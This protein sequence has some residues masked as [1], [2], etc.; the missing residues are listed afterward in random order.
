[1]AAG[2]LVTT[3]FHLELRGH[4]LGPGTRYH[5]D[6]PWGGLFPA[7]KANDRA[8]TSADGG[9]A[10]VDR[11]D[12]RVLTFP[13]GFGGPGG[14]SDAMDDLRALAVAWRRSQGDEELWG[15]LPG[16]GR[17]RVWG[18]PRG[19][20]EDLTMLKAGEGRALATFAAVDD[21]RLYI[22]PPIE[23]D[24][25][26]GS[27][28]VVPNP[29][30]V[31]SPWI[32]TA[33]GAMTGPRIRNLDTDAAWRFDDLVLTAD[34]T[35]VLDLRAQSAF[36]FEDGEDPV[37]VWVDARHDGDRVAT[38]WGI[39]PGGTLIG[40]A[41]EGGATTAQLTSWEAWGA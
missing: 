5:F 27:N 10:G 37:D 39:E 30:N 36:V 26:E 25:E 6:G 41:T 8:D 34:Q 2:D 1:M 40:F 38:R 28:V 24:L 33:T 35:L 4:L 16:L 7:V 11:L 29:G 20:A 9:A 17:F 3:D 31:S 12:V 15:Q 22:E 13:V 19:L 18:R 32:L 14:P 23:T 21:P